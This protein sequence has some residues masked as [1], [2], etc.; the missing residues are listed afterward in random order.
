MIVGSARVRL[1][2]EISA[3]R[4]VIATA[5][6]V[7]ALALVGCTT[8]T[9]STGTPATSGSASTAASPAR[10][11][12]ASSAGSSSAAS[13]PPPSY[14]L[15]L[16]VGPDGSK[17]CSST[18]T[19]QISNYLGLHKCQ[20][21]A[22]S[23]Y[24]T[25]AANRR[26]LVSAAIVVFFDASVQAPFVTLVSSD[27]TGDINTLLVDD[28]AAAQAKGLPPKFSGDPTFLAQAG[29][30]PGEVDVLEAMWL[31]GGATHADDPIL[32]AVLS[33][34]ASSTNSDAPSSGAC[35]SIATLQSAM[36]AANVT[37]M[38]NGQDLCSD[39]W[40]VAFPDQSGNEFTQLFQLVSGSWQAIDR[41]VPC[42][43]GKIPADIVQ[44]ACNSN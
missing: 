30:A 26:V 20:N 2:R 21:L 3:R 1:R 11:S 9:K 25:T 43:A 15:S 24:T 5:S 8:T 10:G 38:L 27:G 42:Q 40:A 28:A 12:G 39:Q 18:A 23:L 41:T 44:P 13:S 19:K 33:Q 7:L 22:R 16:Q 31:D 35:P 6:V 14:T 32:T 29:P 37:G 4:A 17:E 34:A 36:T